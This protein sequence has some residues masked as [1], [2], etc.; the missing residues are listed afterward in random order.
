MNSGTY[1]SG[2]LQVR[3]Y[4]ILQGRVAT[5]LES[6]NLSTSE[7]SII[8]IVS[9]YKDGVSSVEI[10]H[11]LGVEKPLITILV[12]GLIRKG[13]VGKTNHPEDKRIKLVFVTPR[14]LE[15]IPEVERSLQG[16]LF[17]LLNG[18]TQVDLDV[19]K[20]VLETIVK[21]SKDN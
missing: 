14:A 7:W 17:K 3:A 20:K 12:D 21:N 2:L 18:L 8:G 1:R 13:F 11:I 9:E 19:Y 5:T 16:I 4:K 15:L 6:F 10:A